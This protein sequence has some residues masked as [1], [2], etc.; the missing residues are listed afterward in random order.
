MVSPASTTEEQITPPV[1]KFCRERRKLQARELS[2]T[3]NTPGGHYSASKRPKPR[4]QL[5]GNMYKKRPA[6]KFFA[7]APVDSANNPHKWR[8]RVCQIELSLKTKGSLEILS[9]YK[10]DAHLVR[11]HRIRMETLG[12]LLY[13]KDELE[14]TGSALGG[15]REKA[16]LEI[17]IAVILGV[18]YLLLGGRTLPVPTNELDPTSVVCSQIRILL[19]GLRHGGD[20]NVLNS[21]WGNLSVEIIGPIKVPLYNWSSERIFVSIVQLARMPQN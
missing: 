3:R 8:C 10:T 1:G 11:E 7:T 14:L 15:A 19:I 2:S 20:L 12:L 5:T 18:C 9:H 6:F 16:K 4:M 17:P 13:G 21:L